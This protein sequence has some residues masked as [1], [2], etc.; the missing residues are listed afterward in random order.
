MTA[1]AVASSVF[2]DGSGRCRPTVPFRIRVNGGSRVSISISS[3]H[4]KPT[5]ASQILPSPSGLRLVATD[6]DGTLLN[7]RGRLTSRTR[8][9][10]RNIERLGIQHVIVTGRPVASC[11][12]YF[13]TLGYC[14]L[15]VCGQGAQ[16]YDAD[17]DRLLSH[18]GLDSATVRAAVERLSHLV[19]T[20]DLAAVSSGID[21]RF[22]V[23]PEFL[24]GDEN[25]LAPFSEVSADRLWKLPIDKVLI[26]HRTLADRDLAAA[27]LRCCGFDLTAVHAGPDIVELLP[28]GFDKATGLASVVRSLGLSRRD[29]I[30]F[31]DMPNDIPMISWAGY[32]VAMRN[33]HPDVKSA[34]DEI[35]PTNDEDGVAQILERILNEGEP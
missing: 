15:A 31:G 34:A 7:G 26:R 16:I 29:V 9:A 27:A 10:L 20:V 5:P 12:P 1:M 25:Q 4:P 21:G 35:G 23:T 8:R 2:P 3:F 6:L 33:G 19:G 28:V 13:D 18:V 24:R 32:G 11:R 30:A 22:L 17:R 14:G